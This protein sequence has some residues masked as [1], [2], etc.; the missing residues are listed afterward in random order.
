MNRVRTLY[1]LANE[2]RWNS[3]PRWYVELT[4]EFRPPRKGEWFISGAAIPEGYQAPS[5][6]TIYYHIGRKILLQR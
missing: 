2:Y 4:G 6:L 1:P 5:D 3:G